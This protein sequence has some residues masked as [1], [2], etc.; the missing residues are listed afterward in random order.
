M[1]MLAK[2]QV[3]AVSRGDMPAQRSF[4]QQIFGLAAREERSRR[5]ARP[6]PPMQQIPLRRPRASAGKP[7]TSTIQAI[8]VEAIFSGSNQ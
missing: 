7:S 6:L 8:G 5:A 3:R 1:A 4:V 2:G